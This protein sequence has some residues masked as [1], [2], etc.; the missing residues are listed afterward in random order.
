MKKEHPDGTLWKVYWSPMI[1]AAI[2]TASSKPNDAVTLLE[3]MHE[4]D[5]KDMD[6]PM[7]RALANLAAGHPA[8]AEKDFRFIVAH[9]ELDPT[10][11]FY[12]LA[13]LGLGRTLA[14]EGNRPAALDA[15]RKFLALWEHADPDALY[16]VQAR[17][18]LAALQAH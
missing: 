16:L 17:K 3:S 7:R 1:R 5:A 18:E 8:A 4:F 9:R 11:S 14:A 6:L 15:Y 12:P 13:W 10:S 2:A